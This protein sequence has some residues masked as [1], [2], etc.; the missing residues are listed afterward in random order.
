[1]KDFS[2]L[3]PELASYGSFEQSAYYAFDILSETKRKLFD[4]LIIY[5]E[6]TGDYPQSG[7]DFYKLEF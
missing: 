2:S 5:K 7:L 6:Q 4:T 3:F 1:M